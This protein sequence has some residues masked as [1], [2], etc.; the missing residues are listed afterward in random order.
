M[1]ALQRMRRS[2]LA[3]GELGQLVDFGVSLIQAKRSS[4]PGSA[5]D[6]SS[7]PIR[8]GKYE[9]KK[10]SSALIEQNERRGSGNNRI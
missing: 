8:I 7:S 5:M 4:L 10:V 6:R 3:L 2:Y 1:L 9:K